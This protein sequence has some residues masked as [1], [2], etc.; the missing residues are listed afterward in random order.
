[1]I[2]VKMLFRTWRAANTRRN[3]GAIGKLLPLDEKRDRD[4]GWEVSREI[5]EG[6]YPGLAVDGISR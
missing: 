6:I 1:M 2:P 4:L 3:G 5:V